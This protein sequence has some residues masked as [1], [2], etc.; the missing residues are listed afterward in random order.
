MKH[1]PTLALS[2]LPEPQCCLSHDWISRTL[3]PCTSYNPWGILSNDLIQYWQRTKH[4]M[5]YRP[6]RMSIGRLNSIWQTFNVIK[7]IWFVHWTVDTASTYML[8]VQQHHE[9]IYRRQLNA[10]SYIYLFALHLWDMKINLPKETLRDWTYLNIFLSCWK[11][12]WY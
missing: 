3:L 5:S 9:V 2:V 12:N 10:I 6:T 8:I 1:H 4:I 11:W 7:I